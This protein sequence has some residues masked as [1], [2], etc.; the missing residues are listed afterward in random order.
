LESTCP[1]VHWPVQICL[2]LIHVPPRLPTPDLRTAKRRKALGLATTVRAPG[3]AVFKAGSLRA[4][5]S[6]VVRVR[7]I[8]VLG[9]PDREHVSTSVSQL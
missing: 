3:C 8:P 2:P 4:E 7:Q 1:T 9:A 5:P 6:G